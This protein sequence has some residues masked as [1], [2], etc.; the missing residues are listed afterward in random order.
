MK[1]YHISMLN[2]LSMRSIVAVLPEQARNV[3]AKLLKEEAKPELSSRQVRRAEERR[4]NKIKNK[5]G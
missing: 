4:Q 2:S 3:D 5:F 1:T